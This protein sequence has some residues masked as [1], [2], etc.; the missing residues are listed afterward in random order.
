VAAD[1]DTAK[2][3]DSFSIRTSIR[4][5]GV[6]IGISVIMLFSLVYC[7]WKACLSSQADIRVD[8]DSGK[9]AYVRAATL[10]DFEDDEDGFL[11]P[12]EFESV[13]TNKG[14]NSP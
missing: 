6:G 9:G 7:I 1:D 5:L 11:D 10:S 8:S 12:K 3:S 4:T 2:G 13:H 14:Q